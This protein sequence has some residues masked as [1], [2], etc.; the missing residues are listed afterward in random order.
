MN[1][2]KPAKHDAA[3]RET[4]YMRDEVIM[5]SVG[6]ASPG[7]SNITIAQRFR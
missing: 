6:R 1:T 3:H 4:S 7:A 2:R 5:H